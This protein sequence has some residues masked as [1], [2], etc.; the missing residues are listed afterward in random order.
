MHYRRIEG[1]SVDAEITLDYGET[2]KITIQGLPAENAA[3]S[4]VSV[5]PVSDTI[6]SV[7][8]DSVVL[9]EE[10]KATVTVKGITPGA[11]Q[12]LFKV[13]GT[14][15]ET[16]IK[17]TVPMPEPIYVQ[18]SE[19]TASLVSGSTVPYGSTVEL[20][21]ET[22]GATIYYTIDSGDASEVTLVYSEPIVLRRNTTLKAVAIKTGMLS[23][24]EAEFKYIIENK[25]V[26]EQE[27]TYAW[28]DW[29]EKCWGIWG[30]DIETVYGKEMTWMNENEDVAFVKDGSICLIKAGDAVILAKDGEYTVG[31]YTVHVTDVGTGLKLPAGTKLIKE[32]AFNGLENVQAIGVPNGE[33]TI[34]IEDSAF[35]DC[36]NLAVVFMPASV[37]YIGYDVFDGCNGNLYIIGSKD[38]PA[39]RYAE[40]LSIP[41]FSLEHGD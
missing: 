28:T 13:E 32:K 27:I 35:K 26:V 18:V 24:E 36:N 8:E 15:V 2:R 21:T 17:V 22:E 16:A 4:L 7:I 38:S 31:R 9:D 3:G 25:P 29:C 23:S 33:G 34:E 40:K 6:L 5:K 1:L 10:G 30:A 11:T 14:D 19:P 12:C 37:K 39:Q 41:F 20:I